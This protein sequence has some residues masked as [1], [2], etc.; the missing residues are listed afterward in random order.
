[1]SELKLLCQAANDEGI[2]LNIEACEPS[3]VQHPMDAIRICED[4]PGLGLTLDYSHFIDP[5][6]TQSEVEPLHRFARHLHARQAVPGKRVEA[7]D[8]GTID[9]AELSHCS[10]GTI[11]KVLWLLSTWNAIPLASVKLMYGRRLR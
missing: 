10:S 9:F 6:Y 3:V 5:G 2:L 8:K 11:T 7:V 1:V 4:V